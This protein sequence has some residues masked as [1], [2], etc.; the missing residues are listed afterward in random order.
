MDTYTKNRYKKA[1]VLS[2]DEH[3]DDAPFLAACDEGI[4]ADRIVEIGRRYGIPIIERPSI[5]R[6]LFLLEEGCSIPSELFRAIAVLF[7]EVEKRLRPL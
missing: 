1:A 2:Y 4:G 7:H 3:I 5:A 6:S